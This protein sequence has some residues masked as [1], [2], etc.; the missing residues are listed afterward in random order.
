MA[1]NMSEMWFNGIKIAFFSKKLQKIAQQLGSSP[2]DPQSLRPLGTPP[3]D[4]PSVI[5]LSYTGF[6]KTSPKLR[7]CTFQYYWFKPSPFAKSWL[8]A[9][10][11]IF[12]DVIACDLWFRPP[13]S[14]ILATPINWRLPEKL[15]LKIFFF[16]EHLRLCP[17]FLALSSSIPVLGLERVCPR[18]GCPWPWPRIFFVSLA[19]ASS[20]VSSTPPLLITVKLMQITFKKSHDR[21]TQFSI[22]IMLLKYYKYLMN[23]INSWQNQKNRNCHQR[24]FALLQPRW[25]SSTWSAAAASICSCSSSAVAVVRG[26]AVRAARTKQ[27]PMTNYSN[28]MRA[29][30][31]AGYLERS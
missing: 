7:I 16:V 14:K 18:K 13:Q 5:C 22:R 31:L 23:Q 27:I 6:L 28:S 17:W 29:F 10:R 2:P 9:N 4:P 19:L 21:P 24:H 26:A 3:P 25:V 1:L 8:S 11:Q 30:L 12:D 20:L 15:F